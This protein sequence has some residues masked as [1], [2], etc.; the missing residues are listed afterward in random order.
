MT[1]IALCRV[2]FAW[3]IKVPNLRPLAQK[4][5]LSQSLFRGG[6]AVGGEYF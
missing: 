5:Y 6:H 1:R 3:D 4:S 2:G